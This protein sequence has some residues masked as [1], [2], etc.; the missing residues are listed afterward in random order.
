[1]YLI[2]LSLGS[3]PLF[4]LSRRLERYV[5]FLHQVF[6]CRGDV[7]ILIFRLFTRWWL[8]LGLLLLGGLFFEHIIIIHFALFFFIGVWLVIVVDING[9]LV[10]GGRGWW[11]GFQEDSR[12]DAWYLWVELEVS[13]NYR[14]H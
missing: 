12:G 11:G 4:F 7:S 8:F 6:V 13:V 2:G 10:L 14:R 1:M 3:V 5:Y 9:L